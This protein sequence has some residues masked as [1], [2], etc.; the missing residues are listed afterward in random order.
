LLQRHAEKY[1]KP[2]S[3]HIKIDTGMGRI[4][5]SPEDAPDLARFIAAQ[6]FL[7]LDGV[8]THLEVSDSEQHADV[9]YTET[10]LVRFRG[11]LDAIKNAG[12]DPGIVH[13]AASG[14]IL[15]HPASYFDMV[16][17]GILLYGYAP[18]NEGEEKAGVR[19]VMELATKISFLKKVRKGET[20][21]YGRRWTAP[22]DTTV[23]TLPVGYAD[24]LPRT[25]SG[26]LWFIINGKRCPQI[27]TIC[28]DQCMADL[29]PGDTARLWDDVTVFGGDRGDG[30]DA[31]PLTAAS[32]AERSG[33][34]PYE[35][36]CGIG[37]RV[38]RIY[39]EQE[40]ARDPR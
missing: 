30:P 3:V 24:G 26:T 22:Q 2:V 12:I 29:G 33:T 31:V 16:R 17:P 27:G 34:I 11:A 13:A 10:Q 5:A 14:G 20:V 15:H 32:I 9:A 8:C 19:P 37:K 35:I 4:G 7:R 39:A 40:E 18:G 28:M 1:R 25:A 21:S 36:L 38:P 23:A 6:P